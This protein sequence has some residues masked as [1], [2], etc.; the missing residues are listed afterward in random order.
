MFLVLTKLVT[1]YKV[2]IKGGSTSTV[3]MKMTS[4]RTVTIAMGFILSP[5][6]IGKVSTV[7]G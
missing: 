5:V 1:I 6:L 2:L 4:T 3:S 7:K